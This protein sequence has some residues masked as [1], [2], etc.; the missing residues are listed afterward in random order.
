MPGGVL[1][2]VGWVVAGGVVVTGCVVVTGGGGVAVVTVGVVATVGG[3]VVEAT[4][5]PPLPCKAA[6]S[7]NEGK[8]AQA[9]W[10]AEYNTYLP[11]SPVA[12]PSSS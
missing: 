1:G 9:L 3:G 7:L 2:M 10:G 12:L 6:I 4:G 8:L 5:V 11:V